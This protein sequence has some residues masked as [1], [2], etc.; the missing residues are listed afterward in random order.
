MHLTSKLPL[1]FLAGCAAPTAVGA[2]PGLSPEARDRLQTELPAPE[3][4]AFE[5][6]TTT[7]VIGHFDVP[8]TFVRDWFLALPLSVALP[9]TEDIPGVARTELLSPTWGGPGARRRVVLTDGGSALE[10][11]LL[12]ELPDRFKYV[13]W[14]YDTSAAAYVRYGVGEFRFLDRGGET[15]VA[16]T[17]GFAPRGWPASWLL[18]SFVRGEYRHFMEVG[19]EAMAAAAARAYRDQPQ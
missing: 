7:Q 10:Q 13:V 15:E 18:G 9:G 3:V 17:Y 6:L 14:N 12:S 4:E 2:Q 1:L 8:A 11:I 5:A 19:M 16:W